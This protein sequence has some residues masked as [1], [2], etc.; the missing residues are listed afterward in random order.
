MDL[1]LQIDKLQYKC[2]ELEGERDKLQ[3]QLQAI[4]D[5]K[6][7]EEDEKSEITIRNNDLANQVTKVRFLSVLS[8]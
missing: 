5:S 7:N 3:G 6:R 2:L 8:I 4:E 1:K